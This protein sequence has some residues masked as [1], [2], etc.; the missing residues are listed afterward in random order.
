MAEEVG[1]LG[2]AEAADDEESG[3]FCGVEEG[4]GG[5]IVEADGVEACVAD[6]GEVIGRALEERFGEG[7][8]G[9]HAE[10]R[11]FLAEPEESAIGGEWGH[12]G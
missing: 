6:A 11:S 3:L 2:P 9:D 8:V 1:I 7:S 5:E 10:E 12:G 4:A